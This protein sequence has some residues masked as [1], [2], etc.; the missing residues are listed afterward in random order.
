[1]CNLYCPAGR[2][3]LLLCSALPC[4][5]ISL[6]LKVH[7]WNTS[8]SCGSVPF[9]WASSP[10]LPAECSPTQPW[11]WKSLSL[12]VL[13]LCLSLQSEAP[14]P[15]RDLLWPIVLGQS[16]VGDNFHLCALNGDWRLWGP[17]SPEINHHF[18]SF[19]DVKL[20]VIEVAPSTNSLSWPY[21]APLIQQTTVES[22][23]HFWR[24]QV[25]EYYCKC[26]V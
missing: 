21:T 10:K 4:C 9:S 20:G 13:S 23:E 6:R 16:P 26:Q 17:P 11:W 3:D 19:G 8:R 25:S 18:L 2:K 5:G 7:Y 1:M 15:S 22:S 24:E 12:S 14:P